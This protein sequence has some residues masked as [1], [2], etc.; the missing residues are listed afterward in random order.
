M[1]DR[2]GY[3]CT[4]AGTAVTVALIAVIVIGG[5]LGWWG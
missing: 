3:W 2:M 4:L 1:N 5:V